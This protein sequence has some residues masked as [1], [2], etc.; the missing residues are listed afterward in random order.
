MPEDQQRHL[1][2]IEHQVSRMTAIIQQL[3]DCF[4][5]VPDSRS[6]LDLSSVLADVMRSW[7][8][9]T[10]QPTPGNQGLDAAMLVR[11]EPLRVGL[12]CLNV[13]RNACQSAQEQVGLSAHDAGDCWEVRVEDDGPGIPAPQHAQ[14]LSPSSAPARPVKARGR[15]LAVVSSVLKEHGGRR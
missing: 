13:I 2:D 14:I 15:G 12:A 9:V 7:Q 1:S 5:H 10:A 8:A 6:P 11:A 4:R 3:L